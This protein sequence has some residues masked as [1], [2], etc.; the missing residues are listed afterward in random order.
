[1]GR[2]L[3]ENAMPS[4]KFVFP[5]NLDSSLEE[6]QTFTVKMAVKNL[7]VRFPHCWPCIADIHRA[8]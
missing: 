5:A 8:S 6:N 1:M 2:I 4:S 7:Q 3:A